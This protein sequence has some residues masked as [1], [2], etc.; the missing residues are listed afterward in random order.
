MSLSASAPKILLTEPKNEQTTQKT[1][2]QHEQQQ[3][4]SNPA[5]QNG[6]SDPDQQVQP[7]PEQ[8]DSSNEH[9]LIEDD[10]EQARYN[11]VST[12]DSDFKRK[13]YDSVSNFR[14]A[15]LVFPDDTKDYIQSEM[16]ENELKILGSCTVKLNQQKATLLV[17]K[18]RKLVDLPEEEEH[19]LLVDLSRKYIIY[20]PSHFTMYFNYPRF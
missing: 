16:A 18:R 2:I 4:D 20:I 17:K 11:F 3:N 5:E 9:N 12:T 19:K 8:P 6:E 1:A 15:L 10:P 7:E 13:D 14:K